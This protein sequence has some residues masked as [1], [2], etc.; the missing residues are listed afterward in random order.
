MAQANKPS[1]NDAENAKQTAMQTL[2]VHTFAEE[3][4]VSPESIRTY[5]MTVKHD[6][7]ERKMRVS[8]DGAE[9]T[10]FGIPDDSLALFMTSVYESMFFAMYGEGRIGTL[11][12]SEKGEEGAA[13]VLREGQLVRVW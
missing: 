9:N 12:T 8:W 11:L 3:L 4:G 13:A 6:G 2:A 5:P 10:P 1:D 7:D